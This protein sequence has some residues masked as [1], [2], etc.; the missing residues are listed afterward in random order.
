MVS[1]HDLEL[2][3]FLKDSYVL[4]HFQEQ[5]ENGQLFFDY[6]L[7]QG[8]LQQRNAIRI[9]ELAEFPDQ[10]IQEAQRVSQILEDEKSQ[11]GF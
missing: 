7:K 5:I 3:N 2:T 9:L 1:T 6:K 11:S 4:Y 10:V 8:I